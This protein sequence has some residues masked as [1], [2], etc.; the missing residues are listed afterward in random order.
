MN[1][2]AVSVAF[3]VLLAGCPVAPPSGDNDDD[4]DAIFCPD[5]LP[6]PSDPCLAGQCGNELGVGRPCEKG[7]GE[8]DGFSLL[9][10][11]AGI[12]IPEF[13]DNT[14]VHA[15]SMPCDVDDDCGSGAV[16]AADPDNPSNKGCTIV[17]CQGR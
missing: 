17:A 5:D 16:C 7:G 4:E 9:G 6:P 12:C 1:L 15:C 2:H 8:C 3:V 11:E 14:T 13:A 10:G